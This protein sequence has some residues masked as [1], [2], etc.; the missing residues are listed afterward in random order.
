MTSI[1]NISDIVTERQMSMFGHAARLSRND[2]VYR[3]ISCLDSPEQRRKPGRPLL[4]WLRQMDGHCQRVGTDR[5]RAW[6]LQLGRTLRPIRNWVKTRKSTCHDGTSSSKYY[7][8]SFA[9]N[10]KKKIF[11]IM[12][13]II[14]NLRIKFV[15]FPRFYSNH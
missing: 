5:V 9:T 11:F 2:P 10:H 13:Y 4:T 7:S 14:L 12:N 3:I 15:R 1:L 8:T 6:D